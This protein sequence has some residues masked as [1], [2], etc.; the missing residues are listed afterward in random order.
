[1][2]STEEEPNG[3]DGTEDEVNNGGAPDPEIEEKD[4]KIDDV[5]DAS[6]APEPDDASPPVLDGLGG[7]EEMMENVAENI[8]PALE[9]EPVEVVGDEPTSPEENVETPEKTPTEETA[10]AEEEA[11][12]EFSEEV[13]E[14]ALVEGAVLDKNIED[15]GSTQPIDDDSMNV[16]LGGILDDVVGEVCR[17]DEIDASPEEIETSPEADGGTQIET[18]LETSEVE[19]ISVEGDAAK[20]ETPLDIDEMM[21]MGDDTDNSVAPQPQPAENSHSTDAYVETPRELRMEFAKNE[22]I[23]QEQP[24]ALSISDMVAAREADEKQRQEEK[25]K[26]A[27]IRKLKAEQAKAATKIATA[28]RGRMARKTVSER[29]KNVRASK[30]IQAACRGHLGRKRVKNIREEKRMQAMEMEQKRL[31]DEADRLEKLRQQQAE[32]AAPAASVVEESKDFDGAAS[33]IASYVDSEEE[34]ELD[35]D[36]E[37]EQTH[38]NADTKDSK[39]L[40][41]A[42]DVLKGADDEDVDLGVLDESVEVRVP[43]PVD[44]TYSG[45]EDILTNPVA[46]H[47]KLVADSGMLETSLH[48]ASPPPRTPSRMVTNSPVSMNLRWQTAACVLIQSTWRGCHFRRVNR[49]MLT[50]LKRLKKRAI[51]ENEIVQM[52]TEEMDEQRREFRGI[53]LILSMEQRKVRRLEGS[54][55]E[56]QRNHE[57]H[58]SQ[59]SAGKFVDFK[60]S[61]KTSIRVNASPHKKKS[62][63]FTV[64]AQ[65]QA[66]KS[67]ESDLAEANGKI[68]RMNYTIKQLLEKLKMNASNYKV[69]ADEEV[70]KIRKEMFH[71]EKRSQSEISR[72]TLIIDKMG[73]DPDLNPGLYESPKMPP[74][75]SAAQTD[76]RMI[77]KEEGTGGMFK[78]SAWNTPGNDVSRRSNYTETSL[79]GRS[80]GLKS[81]N[82]GF[83]PYTPASTYHDTGTKGKRG[84]GINA[85]SQH[86][87]LQRASISLPE[88]REAVNGS[89]TPASTST[90]GGFRSPQSSGSARYDYT[91]SPLLQRVSSVGDVAASSPSR[92]SGQGLGHRGLE[93][94]KLKDSKRGRALSSATDT[95]NMTAS[96]MGLNY[97]AGTLSSAGLRKLYGV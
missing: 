10:P 65:H 49:L 19:K 52:H 25:A 6:K 80:P 27:E 72:L 73:K 45:E 66:R 97:A 95:P 44:T 13:T 43:A 84:A 24:Q 30:Q 51:R 23:I 40:D 47:A 36:F 54:M 15:K 48:G 69:K 33:T 74:I 4:N 9:S 90:F 35:I 78:G 64:H 46:Q 60:D 83:D 89:T 67:A 76:D 56:A 91:M 7:D 8:S 71:H 75:S 50:A 62:I 12:G 96:G 79:A 14:N 53:E 57:L 37:S 34:L 81:Y 87:G 61:G 63:P 3:L 55:G 28:A 2:A 82:R 77:V 86:R 1:M 39:A 58:M 20:I 22:N 18:P 31:L 85:K 11:A 59:R 5:A 68:R 93:S 70:A 94:P 38:P 41:I 32:E 26:R 29:R 17:S 21:A 16:I 92:R 42:L 88:I